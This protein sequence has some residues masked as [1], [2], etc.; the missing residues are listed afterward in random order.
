MCNIT[1][2]LRKALQGNC[3]GYR[4]RCRHEGKRYTQVAAISAAGLPQTLLLVCQGLSPVALPVRPIP[5]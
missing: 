4:D 1:A 5:R 3:P 2:P